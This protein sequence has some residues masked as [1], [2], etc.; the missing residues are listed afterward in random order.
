MLAS[1]MSVLSYFS[2]LSYIQPM[3]CLLWRELK[4]IS[5]GYLAKPHAMWMRDVA[6]LAGLDIDSGKA[7]QSQACWY[8]AIWYVLQS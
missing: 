7:G 2:V 5:D 1:A 3:Y 6:Y 4:I 8:M